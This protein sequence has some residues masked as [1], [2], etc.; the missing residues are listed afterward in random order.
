MAITPTESAFSKPGGLWLRVKGNPEADAAF[1]GR[2]SYG[3]FEYFGILKDAA[4]ENAYI[5]NPNV[6][7][8]I[9]YHC[10]AEYNT[11]PHTN[12]SYIPT[13]AV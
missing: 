13:Y 5:Q 1:F 12:Y 6:C 8:E 7:V 2:T 11:S 10:Y 4:K 9:E 3:G